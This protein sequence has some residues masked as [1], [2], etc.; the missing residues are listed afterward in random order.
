MGCA[1]GQASMPWANEEGI[2]GKVEGT[3]RLM[4]YLARAWEQE[5]K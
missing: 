2:G 5:S 3:L 4:R 1:V